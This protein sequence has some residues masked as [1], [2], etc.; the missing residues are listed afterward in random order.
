ML[1]LNNSFYSVRLRHMF[2]RKILLVDPMGS[3]RIE[4]LEIAFMYA[5]KIVP[6]K[7]IALV[8]HDMEIED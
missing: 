6:P 5:N 2:I 3:L 4:E 8:S 1:V 7:K